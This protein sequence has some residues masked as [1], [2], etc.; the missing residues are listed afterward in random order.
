MNLPRSGPV[1]SLLLVLLCALVVSETRIR[2]M[3]EVAWPDEAIYLAGA[4]NVLERGTLATN[5]YLTY[6]LLLRGY[7]HRDVHMPGYVLAL[8]PAVAALGDTYWAGAALNAI[9]FAGCVLLVHALARGLLPDPRAA[10]LAAAL[11]ALAP[12]FPGY[13]HIVYPEIVIGLVALAGLAWVVHRGESAWGAALAGLLFGLGP[14]FRETLLLLFP[15]YALL[16]S[17]RRL[18]RAFAPAAL[19]TLL[20]V[21]LLSK[22]RAVHE[23]AIYPSVFEEARRSEAPVA[24]LAGALW[25][26]VRANL[27]MTADASPTRNAEDAVLL[28]LV[29]LAGAAAAGTRGLPSRSRRFALGLGLS[30]LLLVAAMLV[31]YVVRERGGVWGGVRALMAFSPA[32]VVLATPLLLRPRH[33]LLR[34]VLVAAALGGCL[35]LDGWQLHFFR[36]YKG[37]DHEDQTRM[38]RAMERWIDREGPRRIVARCFVYGHSHWP[39]EMIW[40]PPKDSRELARLEKL[41]PYDFVVLNARSPQRPLFAGNA[42]YERVNRGE[43]D[44]EFLIWRRKP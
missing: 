2:S 38:A 40:S 32:L 28:F 37:S 5:F 13:L 14:L 26:N 34:G 30:L 41:L 20:L 36:R 19:G 43:P 23:N 15:V 8:V 7:P 31:L 1:T 16:I 17:P 3:P 22:D 21:S 11:F 33:V 29:L 10:L 27:E 35:W 4:R 42:H 44:P 25:R 39:V 24:T 9:A 6:S 18:L 12:P